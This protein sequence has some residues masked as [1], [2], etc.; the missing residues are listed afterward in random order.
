MVNAV[1]W[2]VTLTPRGQTVICQSTMG[3]FVNI[4]MAWVKKSDGGAFIFLFITLLS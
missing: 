3:G 4:G 2:A 1:V